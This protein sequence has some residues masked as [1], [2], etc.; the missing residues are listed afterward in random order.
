VYVGFVLQYLLKFHSF[1]AS[2]RNGPPGCN[3]KDLQLQVFENAAKKKKIVVANTEKVSYQAANFGHQN[4]TGDLSSYVVG[5]LDKK[6]NTVQLYNIDQ[7]FVMQQS[8]KGF[9]E[10]IDENTSK[11]M[12]F[13]FF[14]VLFEYGYS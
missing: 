12:S 6:T 9:R 14:I 11:V 13:Y 2:F 4:A 1:P 5:V 7:V 8:V 3:P 10:N